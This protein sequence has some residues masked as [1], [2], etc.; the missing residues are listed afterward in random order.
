M[1]F[2][3]SQSAEIL[4]RF[5]FTHLEV[6]VADENPDLEWLAFLEGVHESDLLAPL[7]ADVRIQHQL[8]VAGRKTG[9]KSTFWENPQ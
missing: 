6:L 9:K 3:G 4:P 2:T 7:T 8:S 5:E 1:N